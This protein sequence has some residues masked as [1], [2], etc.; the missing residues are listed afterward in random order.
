M[1]CPYPLAYGKK[2]IHKSIDTILAE[3]EFLN[4]NF[5]VRGFI[6]RDQLFTYNKK[7]V[8][9]LCDEII[10]RNLGL[11]WLVG[12]RIDQINEKLLSK[13][14]AAGCFCIHYG[15]ETGTPEMLIKIGES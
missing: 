12:A 6:F 15:V 13:M 11:K 4:M 9:Q 10:K 7:R 5:G 1:Y 3:I 8:E 2:V 14:N